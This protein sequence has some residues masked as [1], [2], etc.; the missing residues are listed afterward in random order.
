[1]DTFVPYEKMSKKE[2]RAYN[3]KK[4]RGWGQCSPESRIQ[5]DGKAYRRHAKHRH[6]HSEEECICMK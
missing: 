4:R 1:M 5:P 2:K 3:A 6:A